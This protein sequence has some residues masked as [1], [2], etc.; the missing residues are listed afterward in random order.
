[1]TLEHWAVGLFQQALWALLL[2]IESIRLVVVL[3]IISL[4]KKKSVWVGA[5]ITKLDIVTNAMNWRTNPAFQVV[6]SAARGN[7]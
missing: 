4:Y 6:K 1:M 3:V 5:V 7:R 2:V